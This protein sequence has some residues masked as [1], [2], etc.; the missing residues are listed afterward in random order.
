MKIEFDGS[1]SS[2]KK[3]VALYENGQSIEVVCPYCSGLISIAVKEQEKFPV[4]ECNSCKKVWKIET[5][6]KSKRERVWD[7]FEE[8]ERGSSTK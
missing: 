8:W 5:G 7:K 3:I 1:Q 2:L 6:E 4:L